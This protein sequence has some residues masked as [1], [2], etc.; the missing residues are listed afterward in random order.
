M[1]LSVPRLRRPFSLTVSHTRRGCRGRPTDT[2]ERPSLPAQ[3]RLGVR[4]PSEAPRTRTPTGGSFTGPTGVT[5]PPRQWLCDSAC[6]RDWTLLRKIMLTC[7][8]DSI[9]PES[10]GD[11]VV[12]VRPGVGAGPERT[13]DVV[14]TRNPYLLRRPSPLSSSSSTSRGVWCPEGVETRRLSVL[15]TAPALSSP[16]SL[17]PRDTFVR[18]GGLV[19]SL[20]PDV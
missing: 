15:R 3:T 14:P 11:H 12:E 1:P 16:L 13:P 19:S 18:G 7:L 10:E 4:A 2:W 5:P 6:V 17:P 8:L 20:G 9:R